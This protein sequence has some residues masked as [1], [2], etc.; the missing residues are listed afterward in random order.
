MCFPQL[1]SL[2][3]THQTEGTGSATPLDRQAHVECLTECEGIK[4]FIM[5]TIHSD[6][7]V[8]L[9]FF[10]CNKLHLV[11]GKHTR[12]ILYVCSLI[13]W[14]FKPH[15]LRQL[16]LLVISQININCNLWEELDL[17]YSVADKC[18]WNQLL[19]SH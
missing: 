18:H 17:H 12:F 11:R 15:R 10:T 5:I 14:L 13:F 2:S 1:S 4:H 7:R 9:H 6:T 3:A 16:S 8:V 19:D